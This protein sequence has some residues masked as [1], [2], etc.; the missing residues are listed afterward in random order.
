MSEREQDNKV[1]GE[2][3]LYSQNF[4]KDPELVNRLLE[5]TSINSKDIVYEIGP[6]KGVIT[7]ELGKRSKKVIAFEKDERLYS[8]LMEQFKDSN[9]IKIHLGDFLKQDI[10]FKNTKVFS[11]IPFNITA[12][13]IKKLVNIENS[14]SDTYLFLQKEASEK[15]S[16]TPKETLVSLLIKPWFE[17]RELHDFS[18]E[19]FSPKPSVDVVLL[20]IQKRGE[21]LIKER[22]SQLY[23]DFISY[24]F[25]QWQPNIGKIFK[26]IFTYKQLKKLSKD[27]NFGLENKIT[28]LTFEQFLNTFYYFL[29]GVDFK[30]Q[31]E[32][33]DSGKKLQK[34]QKNLKKIHRSRTDKSW[35]RK[36]R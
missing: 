4:L 29:Q 28:D 1:E 10:D 9:D 7:K 26:K 2:K 19:D 32:V 31:R 21:F 27:L 15:Y 20:Q 22:D 13:I 18:P 12:D 30:K 17:L 24:S 35:K 23:K 14:P 25:S 16:G 6:G 8:Y 11:N 3:I 33:F 5:K 36:K 34:Q